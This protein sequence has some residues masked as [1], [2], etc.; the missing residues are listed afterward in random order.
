MATA[1]GKRHMK[2]TVLVVGRTTAIPEK[3]V[4]QAISEGA[5]FYWRDYTG[6]CCARPGW[7]ICAV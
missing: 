7:T 5:E 2:S 3:P 4:N 6:S 1:F